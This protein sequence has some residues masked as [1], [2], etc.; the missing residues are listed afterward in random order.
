MYTV[1]TPFVDESLSLPEQVPVFPLSQMVLLPGEP[2]PLHIF[3]ERYKLMTEMSL[4]GDRLMAIAGLKGTADP[5]SVSRSLFP[6]AGLGKIVLEERLTDGG[7]NLVLVGLKRIRIKKFVQ[8]K[9]F[10]QAQFELVEDTFS[11]TTPALIQS[12]SKDVVKLG[13]E[14]IQIRKRKE[15]LDEIPFPDFDSLPYDTLPLGILC[16]LFAAAL[17]LPPME[18]RMVLEETDA[19]RRAENLIF[20]T[21]FEL[22]NQR[23]GVTAPA[24]LQ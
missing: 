5:G 8:E 6:V 15:I 20:I 7:F 9:P 23:A 10:L 17:A 18:K 22:E 24:P 1:I 16:D 13:K 19:I 21:R 14:L 11:Q 12:L 3:E 2:L 4:S